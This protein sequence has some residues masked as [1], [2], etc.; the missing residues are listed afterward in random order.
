MLTRHRR[1]VW[2]LG[3]GALVLLI[4]GW[5]GLP[6][7]RTEA[8]SP[9]RDP[10]QTVAVDATA[11]KREDVPVY[12]DGLGTV[13]AFNTVTVTARVDGEL[14]KIGF[15]EGQM[16]KV[17]D[18]LAQIDP[19]PFQAVLAQ[20]QAAKAK[21]QAQLQSARADLERYTVLAPENLASKQTLD[22]QRAL[23]A[24]LEAQIKGDQASIENAQTQLQYTT[25][26]SPIQGR[27]GI[28]RVDAG[29]NVHATDTNGI[30]VV[31]QMQ[32]IA[33]IF[34]LPEETLDSVGSALSAG[35]VQVVALSRDGGTEL[36]RG[37]VTLI[38]N[39]IDQSTGTI[40]LKAVFPNI[41]NR[42]WPGQYLTARVL[43]RTEHAALTIPS[44]AVERGPNGMYTYVI[45]PD[46]TVEARPL[47]VAEESGAVM[48]VRDGLH[49]GERVVTSNQFRLQPGA[50]VQISSNSSLGGDSGPEVATV[51]DR[52]PP[53]AATPPPRK[54]STLG[55]TVQ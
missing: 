36:D 29:N 37:T 42:L 55:R 30:V 9:P 14:Q 48:V 23:V 53:M 26:T 51:P 31:T 7:T 54:R 45:K 15:V 24:G 3:A 27:T 17:G 13:Q 10:N 12:L 34:T 18:L 35:K 6:G 49:E 4:V 25:I 43:V 52:S 19:R 50:R 40:R 47:K 20:A 22:S 46:S 2:L 21:D 1:R 38:D 39:Q 41:Q 33:L 16:V 44:N 8:A 32:P 28:R 11:V 5:H